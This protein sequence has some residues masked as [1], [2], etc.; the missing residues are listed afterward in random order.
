MKINTLAGLLAHATIRQSSPPFIRDENDDERFLLGLLSEYYHEINFYY[1]QSKNGTKAAKQRL[2]WCLSGLAQSID[3]LAPDLV[4]HFFQSIGEDA[5]CTWFII[6]SF[7]SFKGI[8]PKYY[9]GKLTRHI[10]RSNLLADPFK[11]ALYWSQATKLSDLIAELFPHATPS[12]QL[13][14]LEILHQ[15][16]EWNQPHSLTKIESPKSRM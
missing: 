9:A 5:E 3:C 2:I 1:R 12:V 8:N 7:C 15:R 13:D 16:G 11:T 14:L 6:S 10:L 4:D